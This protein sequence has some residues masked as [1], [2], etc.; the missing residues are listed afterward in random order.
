MKPLIPL[1]LA[2][3]IVSQSAFAEEHTG[4]LQCFISAMNKDKPGMLAGVKISE[5]ETNVE[6]SIFGPVVVANLEDAS[7]ATLTSIS[8]TLT[9]DIFK[10]KVQFG[11][12]FSYRGQ[13]AAGNLT[14]V[15]ISLEHKSKGTFGGEKRYARAT[16]SYPLV[17]K[18]GFMRLEMF[19]TGGDLLLVQVECAV[20][21]KN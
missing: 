4:E 16:A 17:E 1:M 13:I 9:S 15:T 6:Q 11:L 14:G 12:A 5:P 8:K 21:D 2:L 19:S 10:G 3:A 7:N 18:D 20:T